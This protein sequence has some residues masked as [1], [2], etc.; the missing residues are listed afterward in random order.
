[1]TAAAVA[2]PAA[3]AAGLPGAR[4]PASSRGQR[5]AR[6]PG[7]AWPATSQDRDAAWER[8]AGPPFAPASAKA[9]G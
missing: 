5:P 8:L 3:G 1:M 7:A 9:R 2:T 4:Q 6:S